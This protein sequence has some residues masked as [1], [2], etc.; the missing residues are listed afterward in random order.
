MYTRHTVVAER[1]RGAHGL[2]EA[3]EHGGLEEAMERGGLQEDAKTR[4][5]EET[6]D[7][8]LGC[9]RPAQFRRAT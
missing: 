1:E 5:L 7:S 3:M 4:A 9:L 2:E 8:R 6:A